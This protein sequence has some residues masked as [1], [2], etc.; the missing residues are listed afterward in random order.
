MQRLTRHEHQGKLETPSPGS[1]PSATETETQ[2]SPH[3][4]PGCPTG[5]SAFATKGSEQ[6]GALLGENCPL[7]PGEIAGGGRDGC[8]VSSSEGSWLPWLV[9]AGVG[10]REASWLILG[11]RFSPLKDVALYPP[12]LPHPPDP[13]DSPC[14][15]EAGPAISGGRRALKGAVRPSGVW[16][17]GRQDITLIQSPQPPL[18]SNSGVLFW[19]LLTIHAPE[20][21]QS[22]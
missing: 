15:S 10:C 4:S 9:G 14:A 18:L 12:P 8:Q 6:V 22:W 20:R 13:W 17:L 11:R 1:N 16:G 2:A 19:F 21:D 7:H 5:P 3:H